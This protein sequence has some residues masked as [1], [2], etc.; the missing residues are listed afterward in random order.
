VEIISLN[1]FILKNPQRFDMGIKHCLTGLKALDPKS[2]DFGDAF[3]HFVALELRA[4]IS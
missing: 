4:Y 3:E 1:S 2:K